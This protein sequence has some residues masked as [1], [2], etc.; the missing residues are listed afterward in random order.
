M[1]IR[2]VACTAGCAAMLLGLAANAAMLRTEGRQPFAQPGFE[3][4]VS[5]SWAGVREFSAW[6]PLRSPTIGAD[7]AGDEPVWSAIGPTVAPRLSDA[8]EVKA[9]MG[10][11]FWQDLAR[12]QVQAT[13]P[14]PLPSSVWTL[15]SSLLLLWAWVRRRIQTRVLSAKGL[16]L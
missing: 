11:M 14:V 5:A 9:V 1:S 4:P 6:Q 7:R 12:R 2:A 3:L 13:S 8:F 10:A 16:P 15:A